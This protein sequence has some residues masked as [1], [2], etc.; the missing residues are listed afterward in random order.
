MGEGLGDDKFF[1]G[2][3]DAEGDLA[4]VGGDDGG[5]GGV[6]LGVEVEV[7]EGEVGADLGADVGGVFADAAGEDEGVEAVHGGG[8]RGDEFAGLVAEEVDGVG[9]VRV[10]VSRRAARSRMSLVV[11]ETPMRPHWREMKSS[12]WLGVNFSVR[13]R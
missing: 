5:V 13:R 6:F 9:G 12:S 4:L 10:A 1:V 11:P 3:D 2:G 7:E 8:E